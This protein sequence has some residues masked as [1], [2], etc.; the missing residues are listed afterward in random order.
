[1]NKIIYNGIRIETDLKFIQFIKK[2]IRGLNEDINDSILFIL[3][4]EGDTSSS[5]VDP[6]VT[7]IEDKP[8]EET[9]LIKTSNLVNKINGVLIKKLV[10]KEF[11]INQYIFK[12]LNQSYVLYNES[13][14][15]IYLRSGISESSYLDLLA[16]IP[17]LETSLDSHL[18]ISNISNCLIDKKALNYTFNNDRVF[19]HKSAY[20]DYIVDE[21][22][23]LFQVKRKLLE[24][25]YDDGFETLKLD[26]QDEL[27][28]VPNVISYTI[29]NSDYEPYVKRSSPIVN[30]LIMATVPVEWKIKTTSI[31][32]A[33]DIK[34][35]YMNLNLISNLTSIIIKD[36]NNNDLRIAIEWE[37]VSGQLGDK[38]TINDEENNYS[39]QVSFNCTIHFP[40]LM[41][42][43]PLNDKI[44]NKINSLV[45]I[46]RKDSSEFIS[47]NYNNYNNLI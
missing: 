39:H 27:I 7:L 1:M 24:V 21:P 37:L 33:F 44:I 16:S 11:I 22:L 19:K 25:L 8:L 18:V 43:K 2:D 45:K 36:Y 26:D 23:V 14:C 34:N 9:K 47:L 13:R 10:P 17:Y 6:R 5:I 4:K 29:N 35:K 32:K 12:D 20:E 38:S 46:I 15:D 28:E 42:N 3:F 31:S 40:I 30:K 41:G